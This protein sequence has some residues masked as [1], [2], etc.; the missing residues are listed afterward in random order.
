MLHGPHP[1][2]ATAC[3]GRR[4]HSLTR[5][6]R[7]R[8]SPWISCHYTGRLVSNQQVFDSSVERGQPLSFFIG[9]GQVIK[10]WDVGILGSAEDVSTHVCVCGWVCGW[11]G[12]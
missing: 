1:A 4:L 5:R 12:E 11:V 6:S 8:L 2:W 3:M 7:V 10:G 9:V